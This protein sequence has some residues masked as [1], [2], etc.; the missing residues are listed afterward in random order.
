MILYFSIR[1]LYLFIKK[2][3]IFSKRSIVLKPIKILIHKKAI[4]FKIQL[5]IKFFIM[6]FKKHV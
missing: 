3:F 5:K 4:Y 6:I 2:S 1:N